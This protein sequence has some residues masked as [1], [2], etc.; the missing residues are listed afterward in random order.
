MA[1]IAGIALDD[2][3]LTPNGPG[4]VHEVCFAKG[5]IAR[6][7]VEKVLVS[8]TLADER[9][10]SGPT[11]LYPFGVLFEWAYAAEQ[12]KAVYEVCA[13]RHTGCAARKG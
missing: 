9:E 8:H 7:G 1:R 11:L 12:V 13:S 2:L 5:R 6:N 10:A 4:L 3:V